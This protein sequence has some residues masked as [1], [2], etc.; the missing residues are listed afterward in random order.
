MHW[1]VRF[2]PLGIAQTFCALRVPCGAV[3][4]RLRMQ[5]WRAQHSA[6]MKKPVLKGAGAAQAT[7]LSRSLFLA[8]RRDVPRHNA[9]AIFR[10]QAQR[11]N[12]EDFGQMTVRQYLRRFSA[13]YNV[14]LVEQQQSVAVARG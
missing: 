12:A 8:L 11:L 14:P 5:G 7:A 13:R 10:G 6:C 4:D 3:A 1:S 9:A 2:A